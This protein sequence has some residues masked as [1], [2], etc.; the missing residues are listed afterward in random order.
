MVILVGM[1]GSI[2][3]LLV[4]IY[5]PESIYNYERHTFFERKKNLIT[6]D[7]QDIYYI[8]SK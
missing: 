6:Y 1:A 8:E 3:N 2:I 4:C 7:E 5:V